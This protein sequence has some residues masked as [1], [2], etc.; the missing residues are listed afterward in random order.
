MMF[1]VL[2]DMYGSVELVVFPKVFNK[3]YDLIKTDMVVKVTGKVNIKEG[4]KPKILVNYIEDISNKK[5]RKKKGIYK[6][7]KR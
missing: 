1:T 4:E 5:W 3:F 6:N 7:T 2:E